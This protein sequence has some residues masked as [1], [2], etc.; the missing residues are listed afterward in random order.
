MSFANGN[1][2]IKNS[3]ATAASST[4][5]RTPL[6]FSTFRAVVQSGVVLA[7][8]T[9]YQ[10]AETLTVQFAAR[11]LEGR[12]ILKLYHS[13][14]IAEPSDF[15]FKNYK[16]EIPAGLLSRWRRQPP[17][18]LIPDRS[19][20]RVLTDMFD[21]QGVRPVSRLDGYERLLREDFNP[22]EGMWSKSSR[23]WRV[24]EI[25]ICLVGHFLP[26]DLARAF[27][28]EFFDNI[29]EQAPYAPQIRLAGSRRLA[30]VTAGSVPDYH[31][32]IE[33]AETVSG[34]FYAVRL[35]TVDT[36]FPFGSGSLERLSRTF[37]GAGKVPA[38]TTEEKCRM[39]EMFRERPHDAF[40]YAYRDVALTLLVYEQM[41]RQDRAIYTS[42]GIPKEIAPP[43]RP[44]VGG[45]V[46]SF[47]VAATQQ[48]A[49]DSEILGKLRNLKSL[50]KA[51]G[52]QRFAAGADCSH[53]GEQTGAVHGGL[54]FNR[55]PTKLWH[56]A[57]LRDVD[58]RAAYSQTLQG[59]NAYWGRPV[60][61]EPGARR[62]TLRHAV[63]FVRQHADDDAWFIRVTGDITTIPNVLIPSTTDALTGE[64]YRRRRRRRKSVV[65]QQ[66]A[67]GPRFRGK[68]FSR[69]VESGVVTA[70]TW[71]VIQVFPPRCLRDYEN[72]VVDA[73]VFYPRSLVAESGA[74]YDQKFQQLHDEGLPWSAKLDPQISRIVETTKLDHE[75]IALKFPIGSCAKRI[76]EFRREA[77][78]TAGVGSGQ[79]L[80]WKLQ[81]NSMFG[82][83]ASEH[84][85][86]NNAVLAN[87]ITAQARAEAFVLT[88]ALNAL[89]TITDGCLYRRDRIPR[90]T[91]AECLRRQPDY[92]LRHAD[93]TSGN[94]FYDPAEIPEDDAEFA[95]W[96]ATH[97][98][99]FLGISS[100]AAS[101]ILIHE[102]EHKMTGDTGSPAFDGIAL[103]GSG[104]HI[105]VTDSGDVWLIQDSKMR[106]YGDDSKV[107]LAPWIV[108]KY[109][110][111]T[112][113]GLPPV[114]RDRRLLKLVPA[115]QAARRVLK[116]AE[117]SEVLL[118][119]GF[120]DVVTKAY[121]MLKLSTF[122]FQTPR[123]LAAFERQIER[124]KRTN[125]VG[126]DLLVLRRSYNDHPGGSLSDG[127]CRLYQ[128][129]QTGGRDPSKAFNLREDHWSK[130]LKAEI[131]RRQRN[132]ERNRND[133]R[134]RLQVSMIVDPEN[135]DRS[136]P[137]IILT[138]ET[139]Q[140]IV[141]ENS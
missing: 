133:A 26:A 57:P 120:E 38:F 22:R 69:R 116:D 1:R 72:L 139:A 107:V 131:R 75:Y 63:N 58:M 43:M 42:L 46:S 90:C 83:V 68:L 32:I 59:K 27:G 88:M 31:P 24:P 13:P 65:S 130:T 96:F 74:A 92:P 23:R 71:A 5:Q 48:F 99:Q 121:S 84:C 123:Q 40:G 47:L 33:F 2:V 111:D 105:K 110:S 134:E 21:L 17:G 124:L 60:L 119:L 132:L 129:V 44:T 100:E 37:V 61:L 36:L 20:V 50:M 6:S 8:D 118:P 7:I 86:V 106:G 29:F 141:L 81:V 62:I 127:F 18:L 52:V 56:E 28:H 122:V 91:F 98:Q 12:R 64:N 135:R 51:G 93:E 115:A 73:I 103:D 97:A 94:P 89:Q 82:V 3:R 11:N 125:G 19:P 39:L 138:Q 78:R 54:L 136:M 114:T 70:D 128:Y 35:R 10:A 34:H 49:A 14:A 140:R 126:L 85:V 4:E 104:N 137:G 112:L 101:R 45:R 25:E 87:Q 76:E 79:E 15:T 55:T 9:E 41:E 67:P 80:A 16:A 102:L 109:A 30:F 113:S 77:R 95:R 117:L 66:R 108:E 53:F